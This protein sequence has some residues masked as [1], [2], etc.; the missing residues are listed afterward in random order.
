MSLP[1]ACLHVVKWAPQNGCRQCQCPQGKLH[2]YLAFLK[3]PLRSAGRSDPGSFPLLLLPWVLKH[4]GFCL[5]PQEWSLFPQPSG[6]PEHKPPPAF[7]A[8]RS[9][10]LSSQC[11]TCRLGS[12]NVVSE[13]ASLGKNFCNYNYSPICGSATWGY[14]YW[15]HCNSTPPTHL[16]VPSLHP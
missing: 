13:L 10:G 5:Y 7:K 12:P 9:G 16:M 14:R 4:V 2:L 1:S 6:T 8:K 15:L 3:D 11:R